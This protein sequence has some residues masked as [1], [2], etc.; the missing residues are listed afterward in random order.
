MFG[1]AKKGGGDKKNQAAPVPDAKLKYEKT[2][3]DLRSRKD[4]I[5]D[6]IDRIDSKVA[7]LD[8]EI[9]SLLSQGKKQQARNKVTEMKSLQKQ[10]EQMQTKFNV[11]TQM[12]IQIETLE[13]DQGIADAVFNAAEL[14]KM[15]QE[16]ND[17]LQDAMMDWNEFQ[18]SQQ[19]TSELWKQMSNMG[20]DN[21]EIDAEFEKY[22]QEDDQQKALNLQKQLN[23]VPSNQIPA[24]QQSYQQKN[25][26]NMDKQL[27]E[28][29]D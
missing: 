11:L 4:Q 10:I 14:G 15:Q 5:Q 8:Q 16:T 20:V 23:T 28:L 3:H 29:L 24:Q 26:N 21:E 18:T 27:A 19:E 7:N 9:R 22:M 2:L 17:K 13:Q 6:N 1:F 12:T 25:Q